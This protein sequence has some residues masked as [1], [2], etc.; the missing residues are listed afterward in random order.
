M[1]EGSLDDGGGGDGSGDG[2]GGSKTCN[3]GA[4]R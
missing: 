2:S 4:W 1:K 3:G